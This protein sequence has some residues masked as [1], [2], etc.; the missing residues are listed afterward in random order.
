MR[1]AQWSTGRTSETDRYKLWMRPRVREIGSSDSMSCT[2][3][4]LRCAVTLVDREEMHD[5]K[6]AR[7]SGEGSAS[8]D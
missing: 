6:G 1:A 3:R 8:S 2:A 5:D 7:P 4:G